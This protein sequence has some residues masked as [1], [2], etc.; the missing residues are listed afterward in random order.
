MDGEQFKRV[1][2]NIFDNAFQAMGNSG[3]I[4]LK[5]YMDKAA[6]RVFMDIADDGPGMKEDDKDKIFLPISLQKK[7]G[8]GLGWL[9][10]TKLLWNTGDISG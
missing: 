5:V 4:E 8:T 1:M 10:Q 2:I 7:D 9:L 6:N 3:N